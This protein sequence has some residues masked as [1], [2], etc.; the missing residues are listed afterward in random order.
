MSK[1]KIVELPSKAVLKLQL[2]SFAVSKALWQSM[3]EEGRTLNL[4]MNAEIDG[5]L[6]KDIF[7][8]ALSSRKIE[9]AVWKCLE[10]CTINDIRITEDTFEPE[11]F[12]DDYLTVMFEV[13]KENILPF[14]KS[15]YAKYGHLLGMIK[16]SQK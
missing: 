3:M 12:R 1:E 6:F 2:S 14:T 16:S 4:D 15:L 13:A 7:C 5:N 10:K 8:V 9:S 11:E